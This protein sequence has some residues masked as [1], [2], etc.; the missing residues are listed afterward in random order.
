MTEA[1]TETSTET[2]RFDVDKNGV[3]LLTVDLPNTSMNVINQQFLEDFEICVGRVL[4]DE[5]IKGAVITSGKAAFMAGADLGMVSNLFHK[6][7][8]VKD[9]FD[10]A[11]RLNKVL[12]LMET[13]GR[14][15]KDLAKSGTKPFAAAVNGLAL[16][17]GF[18]IILATHYRVCGDDPKGQLGF[19]EVQ[20]GLLP[21]AGG[22]QRLPRMIG[23]QAAAA[24]I[25]SGKPFTP[26]S[27]HGLGIVDAVV[28]KSDTIAKAKEW[29]LSR[30]SALAPWDRRGFVYPGG[31]GAMH[32][33]AVRTFIGAN[34]MAA[35][36]SHHNYPAIQAILSCLYEGGIVDFDRAILV[37]TKYF[38]TLLQEGTAKYMIRSLFITKQA[39]EKG[40]LRPA[41]PKKKKVTCLGMVGAGMMGAGIAYVSAQAGMN[42]ILLD[43]NKQ[44]AEKGKDHAR[45]L[46][47]K[48]ISRG[49][50]T[51]ENGDALLDRIIPT[52]HFEDLKVCDFV[53]EAVFEDEEVKRDIIQ[54]VEAVIGNDIVLASNT[55]TLPITG[56]ARYFTRPHQFIGVH[57]FSPV[58]KMPLVEI[59]L[60]DHTDDNTCA[61]ALDYVAQ[62]RK[63]PIVVRDSRGF[64]TSRCF[65]TYVQEGYAMVQEGIAPSLVENA[66]KFSGMPVGPLAVGDEVSL[67]LG[68]KIALATKKSLGSAYVASPADSFVEKMVTQFK[69]FG[70]KN[71]KGCYVYPDDGAPKYLWPEL[72][73]HFP[74]L[75]VQPDIAEIKT[76]LIYRQ[77]IEAV[78]C[79]EEGVLID[80]GSGDIGAIFG[81][82]FAPFTGGP[83]S[84]IDRI[85]VDKF[86]EKADQLS[87]I[88]GPRFLPP[89]KLREMAK[90]QHLFYP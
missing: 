14:P 70:R 90:D 5:N 11:F 88:Y 68:Y 8:T 36:K 89:K 31:A 82:G 62:I 10:A 35:Q 40:S 53:I 9:Q 20:I 41:K 37:E 72:A 55:S 25:T 56:L 71:G 73:D 69:R 22:T 57:F 33:S 48:E 87:K 52:V 24:A 19:P 38:V 85:G 28:E 58:H 1:K 16:G 12:R 32:P 75:K 80:A 66:G 60:G 44:S 29:V 61:V 7:M 84:F 79:F 77:V 78:R 59:I 50:I 27:A 42:V 18:E 51:Q 49:K 67:D 47:H 30:K 86:V 39:V 46:V 63:T 17:G 54:K 76:R 13:G 15:R 21:G 26:H 6:E 34:A 2:I 65:G 74:P 45:S 3:A 83:F 81:W 64:Y 4:A 23:I 43:Q